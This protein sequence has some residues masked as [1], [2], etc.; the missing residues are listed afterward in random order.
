MSTSGL[1]TIAKVYQ[2]KFRWTIFD[3]CYA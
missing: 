1:Y 2:P 3:Q